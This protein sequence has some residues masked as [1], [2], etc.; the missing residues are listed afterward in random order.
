MSS[1]SSASAN[2]SANDD[3]LRGASAFGAHWRRWRH[4]ILGRSSS[5]PSAAC[6]QTLGEFAKEMAMEDILQVPPPSI[7]SVFL[8]YYLFTFHFIDEFEQ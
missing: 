6:I 8:N 5:A 2:A 7:Q 4:A 3:D 1:R